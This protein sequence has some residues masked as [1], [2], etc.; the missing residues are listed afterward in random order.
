MKI[1]KTFLIGLFVVA[2]A[3]SCSDNFFDVNQSVNGPNSATPELSLP[4]AQK[5]SADLLSGDYNSMNTLGNLW[6]Y[7]WAAGGDFAYFREET[8]YNVTSAFRTGTFNN[9]Y[10]L[11]LNNYQVID[12]NLDPKYAN[13]RA[14]A[15]IM[16]AFHYQYLVD[17]YGN[18]PY[19]QALQHINNPKPAYDDAKTIYDD[20]IVQL[21]AAQ[22]LIVANSSD[23]SVEIPSAN[24]DVMCKGNMGQ[25]LK[26]ANTLK[27]RILL[28]QTPKSTSV[29]FSSVT[30]NSYGFLGAGETVYCNPGYVNDAGKQNP[31]YA[32]FGKTVAGDPASNA[33]ATR[34][35]P[36]VLALLTTPALDPRKNKLFAFVGTGTTYAGIAQNN[37]AGPPSASLSGLGS[38]IIKSS[39]QNAII[40]QAAESY[41][42]QAEAIARGVAIPGNEQTL[43][44]SGVQASFDELGAGTAA[45]YLT[46]LSGIYDTSTLDSKIKS[47]ITQKYIAL[48]STNGIENWIEWRRTGYP[49][50]VIPAPTTITGIPVRLL[51]PTTEY[52]S[53]AANVPV[54]ASPFTSKVFWDN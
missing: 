44:E 37:L 27:L 1:I 21:T 47:I 15:K 42:L 52:S 39:T 41:F 28:R 13:F 45:T 24:Q 8:L 22:A 48:M 34:A 43:Y 7:A 12:D 51:Y 38:G 4:V 54:V 26:F 31:L 32:N 23:P 40:M 20:L 46:T 19:S 33:G 16:K 10:L 18:I 30:G 11:P 49:T 29:D 2:S 35:T 5:F 9:A 36:N 53:N 50:N 3:T 25:W 14:I 17:T 6:S